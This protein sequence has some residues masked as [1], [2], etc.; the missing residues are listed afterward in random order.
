[1]DIFLFEL[2]LE[3]FY[4]MIEATTCKDS[5]KIL[6]RRKIDRNISY[7][8][9]INFFKFHTNLIKSNFNLI[10]L[11]LLIFHIDLFAE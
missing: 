5:L 3:I 6:E 9:Y 8:M 1:M 7:E 10:F 11:I 2:R 4:I